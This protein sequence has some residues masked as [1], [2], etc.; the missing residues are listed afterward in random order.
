MAK[1]TVTQDQIHTLIAESEVKPYKMGDKTT[2]VQLT[3]PAGFVI[4]ESSSCVDPA[5]FDE[6]VGFE[7]CMDRI[8]NK[9]WELEGYCLQ[10]KVYENGK[11]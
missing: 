10:K 7:I 4:I 2:V 3:T 9:L 5:N 6:V 11:G 1:N 8:A